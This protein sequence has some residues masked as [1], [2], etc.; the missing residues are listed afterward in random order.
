MSATIR[1]SITRADLM[2]AVLRKAGLSRVEAQDMVEGVLTEITACLV[3]GEMV[4]L[5][6]F[7]SFAVRSKRQRIGRNPKTPE[8]IPIAP[9]R[10]LVFKPSN[11]MK[12]KI[13]TALAP[14]TSRSPE[15]S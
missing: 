12:Q 5:S 6:A 15:T 3:R 2:K 11:V 14:T 1:K 10:V 7:G 4:K 13:K 8:E 9:R